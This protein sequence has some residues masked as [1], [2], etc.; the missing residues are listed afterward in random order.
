[1][2]ELKIT[3][4]SLEACLSHLKDL[5][6]HWAAEAIAL[7]VPCD[8]CEGWVE[9]SDTPLAF[10]KDGYRLIRFLS[11]V[12]WALDKNGQRMAD[13]LDRSKSPTEAQAWA[14]SIIKE[15][16]AGEKVCYHAYPKG[17]KCP[18]CY[19]KPAP[20][21]PGSRFRMPGG[22][23]CVIIGSEVTPHICLINLTRN[24]FQFTW[25]TF[26]GLAQALEAAG[27]ERLVEKP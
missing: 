3:K 13:G 15:H 25:D 12:Y 16:E 21:G 11:S 7:L 10:V 23:E 4:D 9:V 2:A 17:E 27:A 18:R 19:P 8:E 22:D 20:I 1:M 5:G 6:W 14:D 26:D 24:A